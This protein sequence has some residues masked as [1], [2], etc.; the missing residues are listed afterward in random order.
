MKRFV[1]NLKYYYG[2]YG[3]A[4]GKARNIR[5]ASIWDEICMDSFTI[6][7]YRVRCGTILHVV[8]PKKNCNFK[9]I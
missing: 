7:E 3:R 8:I 2:R 1:S 9:Y 4:E 5:I 6:T